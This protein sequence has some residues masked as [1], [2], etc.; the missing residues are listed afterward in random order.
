[1]QNITIIDVAKLAGVAK[2]TVSRAFASPKL[3]SEKTYVKVMSAAKELNYIPNPIARAL[4]VASTK[5]ITMVIP[6]IESIIMTSI[7]RGCMHGLSQKGYSLLVLDSSENYGEEIDYTHLMNSSLTDGVIFCYG[8]AK[9]TTSKVK[10]SLPI[11]FIEL[12][13]D[14]PQVDTIAIEFYTGI[15][16]LLQHLKGLG[17]RKIAFAL[18][19]KDIFSIGRQKLIK[20]ALSYECLKIPK[21]YFY[22]NN[23]TLEAGYEAMKGLLSLKERPT[24]VIY[25]SDFMAMGGIR[26]AIDTG[27][28]VPEDISI[29]GT[30]D[31]LTSAYTHPQIT[32]LCYSPYEL[33]ILAGETML[34]RILNPEQE[35]VKKTLPVTLTIRESTALAP[36]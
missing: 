36:K 26:A 3:V 8:S 16:Q 34:N 25:I 18:G 21:E 27:L 32:T 14:D 13:E 9:T 31:S 5:T 22:F 20:K 11:V 24:A 23:W 19:K 35:R 7:I 12:D 1:M 33:G 30:D 28:K 15:V 2:S 6:N 29:I 10:Q 4:N 17:H